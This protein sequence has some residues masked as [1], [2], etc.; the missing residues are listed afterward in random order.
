MSEVLSVGQRRRWRPLRGPFAAQGRSYIPWAVPL[1]V[2]ALWIIASREHWMSEQILPAPSLVW[3]SAL[4]YGSGEL[5][6]HLWIS[7]QRLAWGLL[8]GIASGLAGRRG[9]KEC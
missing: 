1:V 5:W 6:G 3:Q 4:E 7:L 2:A 9:G 8:A